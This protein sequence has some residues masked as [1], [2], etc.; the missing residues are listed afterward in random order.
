MIALH[1]PPKYFDP[2]FVSTPR[3]SRIF[4]KIV[5]TTLIINGSCSSSCE[6]L[7]SVSKISGSVKSVEK[8]RS[9]LHTLRRN[10]VTLCNFTK[11]KHNLDENVK[12]KKAN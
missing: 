10:H 9:L 1:L 11:L 4:G 3:L 5:Y 6:S 2:T 8:E 12:E 7:S